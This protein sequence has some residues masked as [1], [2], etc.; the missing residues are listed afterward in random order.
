MLLAALLDAGASLPAVR[1]AVE[2]VVPETV[3]LTVAPTQRAGIRALKAD[4]SLRATDQPHRAWRE[5]RPA[6]FQGR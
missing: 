6:D 4:V 2:A 5:K 1:A 3:E